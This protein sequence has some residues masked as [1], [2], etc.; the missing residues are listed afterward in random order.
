MV[1]T[2]HMVS[3]AFYNRPSQPMR[4][5]M[6]RGGDKSTLFDRLITFVPRRTAPVNVC[7]PVRKRARLFAADAT[8]ALAPARSLHILTTPSASFA[9]AFCT[10][11][12]HVNF[13]HA[14][15]L[16]DTSENFFSRLWK[17][18]GFAR[19]LRSRGMEVKGLIHY[20]IYT[21]EEPARIIQTGII[22]V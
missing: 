7:P 17:I 4:K 18:F 2:G 15:N 14:R 22:P 5:D 9:G 1:T 16:R 8:C 20:I 6:S 13:S 3:P 12:R 19:R 10:H 21:Q 11:L